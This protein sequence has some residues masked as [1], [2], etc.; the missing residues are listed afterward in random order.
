MK[1][2]FMFCIVPASNKAEAVYRTL[3]EKIDERCP[4][5]I[6][7]TKNKAILYLDADSSALLTG[8]N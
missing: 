4:A 8:R 1:A 6:L 3:S 5:T 7:R 2:E